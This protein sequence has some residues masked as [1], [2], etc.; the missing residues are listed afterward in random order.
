MKLEKRFMKKLRRAGYTGSNN[1]L[2]L[3]GFRY[4]TKNRRLA[5][6][7]LASNREFERTT[8]KMYKEFTS[9]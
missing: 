1:I 5:E 3:Q 9:K 8:E 4:I 7:Q 2:N 6:A